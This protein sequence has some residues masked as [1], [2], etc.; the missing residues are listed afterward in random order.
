MKKLRYFAASAATLAMAYG[1]AW[2]CQWAP[3]NSA[4]EVFWTVI[5]FSMFIAAPVFLLVGCD[6]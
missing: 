4:V 1:A 2:E 5:M 6:S 3:G